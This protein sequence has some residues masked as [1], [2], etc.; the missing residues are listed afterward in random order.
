MGLHDRAELLKN[1]PEGGEREFSDLPPLRWFNVKA[2]ESKESMFAM[3]VMPFFP[4]GSDREETFIEQYKH[5][6]LPVGMEAG[7]LATVNRMCVEKTYPSAGIE[8][9]FCRAINAEL[10]QTHDKTKRDELIRFTSKLRAYANVI[11]TKSNN[12]S[13]VY[14]ADGGADGRI[15]YLPHIVEV[16]KTVYDAIVRELFIDNNI[17]ENPDINPFNVWKAYPLQITISKKPPFRKMDIRYG[18]TFGRVGKAIVDTSNME[19]AQAHMDFLYQNIYDLTKIFK[20]PSDEKLVEFE[21]EAQAFAGALSGRRSSGTGNPF[22][23]PQQ[24]PAA[25]RKATV[26]PPPPGLQAPPAQA[27]APAPPAPAQ[28]AQEAPSAPQTPSPAVGEK[29]RSFAPPPALATQGEGKKPF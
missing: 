29:K 11:P 27:P 17:I 22:E 25:Q 23:V 9:P 19:Q 7:K 8:C 20:M 15:P 21:Q 18:A 4:E 12:Q 5:Y 6:Q 16:N 3:F 24:A 10:T 28:S 26:P 1:L 2:G 13:I 14:S